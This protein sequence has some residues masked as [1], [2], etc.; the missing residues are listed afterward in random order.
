MKYGVWEGRNE[1]TGTG[2]WEF[3]TGSMKNEVWGMG[4]QERGNR[5]WE[6]G[7]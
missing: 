7:I 2:N 5:N 6:L 3:K 1:E 4:I